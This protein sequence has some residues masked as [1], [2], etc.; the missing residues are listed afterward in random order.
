MLWFDMGIGF[1]LIRYALE[2]FLK[3]YGCVLFIEYQKAILLN[4][5]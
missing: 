2:Y 5:S 3:L 4:L 1:F